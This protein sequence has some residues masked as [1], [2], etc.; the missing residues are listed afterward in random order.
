MATLSISTPTGGRS[1]P[2]AATARSFCTT[3]TGGVS[4][5]A[6]HLGR[7]PNRFASTRQ[8]RES[9]PSARARGMASWC[10]TSRTA[11]SRQAGPCPSR[12]HRRGLAPRRPLACGRRRARHD[13]TA[14]C[15]RP[16]PH[17]QN[18]SSPRRRGRRAGVPSRRAAAG[19]RE[20]GRDD[21]ALGSPIGR[22]ACEMPVARG[23]P[24]PV[25]PGRPVPRAGARR[26]SAWSWE[27]AEGVECRS[28]LGADRGGERTWSLDFLPGAGVLA[29]ADVTGV[30]LS[31]PGG[32]AA[33]FVA[34]PGTVGTRCG[35]RWFLRDH[36]RSDR[37]APLASQ[38]LG[39]E[40]P[41]SWPSRAIRATGRP[42]HRA[43]SPRQRRPEPGRGPR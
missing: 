39:S 17:S 15:P 14:R 20:L 37:S 13:P 3:W 42:S 29:T 11:R 34:L 10:A 25:Q 26:C 18:N 43:G 7:Y 33:A 35:S 9:S 36:K 4:C 28:L 40:R 8:A 1:L 27:V 41:A 21:A 6:S 23:S 12:E 2:V 24:A 38:A 32:E 22:A 5:V 19:Q 16:V 30:R 31:V